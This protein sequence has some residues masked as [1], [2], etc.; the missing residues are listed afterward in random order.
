MQMLT[1]REP[2][3][4]TE[5]HRYKE[6]PEPLHFPT[7]EE[8]PEG[9]RHLK[10][11]TL[12]YQILEQALRGQG[13]VGSDQF[14][15][16]NARDPGVRLAPDVFVGFGVP[17]EDFASWKTWERGTPEL[18]VEIVSPSDTSEG[19]WQEKLERYHELGARELVRF[20]AEAAPG[21]RLRMW[22]RVN[23]N[24]LERELED[25]RG[26]SD[27]LGVWWVVVEDAELGPVLRPAHDPLGRE[28]LLTP[29]EAAERRV[30]ELEAE[31][32]R[33]G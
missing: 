18:C 4:S 2:R 9:R 22:D 29:A 28:L 17:D 5:R 24:L 3:P 16:W 13:S 1:G 31:L 6:V 19:P 8:V 26:P 23:E 32:G 11:R 30:A 14:V 12:L 21:K 20:D 10:L 15:Y 33:R 25:D 7:E 27:V